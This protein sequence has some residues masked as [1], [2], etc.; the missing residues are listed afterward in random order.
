LCYCRKRPAL[1]NS[2]I[3]DNS[4]GSD[5]VQIESNLTVTVTY[6]DVQGGW[7]GEGNIDAEPYFAHV[8]FWDTNGTPEDVNDDFW[9]QA[10]YHLQSQAGR[11]EPNSQTWVQDAVTSPCIDAGN[12]DSVR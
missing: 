7:P 6:T 2:I 5:I 12:P 8:G 10:D 1:T 9:V 3:Y 11:W 4:A